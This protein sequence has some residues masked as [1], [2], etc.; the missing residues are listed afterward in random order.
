MANDQEV[1]I[2]SGEAN[3]TPPKPSP[4]QS[5]SGWDGKLRVTKQATL[6]NPEALSDPDYS[7]EDAPPVDQINADEDLLDDEDPDEIDVQHSRVSSMPALRLERF[8]RLR[9][10]CLR[11]N[12]IQHIELPPDFA[13]TLEELE[14][15]DNLVKHVGG[16]ED[17]TELRSLDLSYNKLKHIKNIST[18]TK[19]DHL[20]FVQNRLSKIENL[21]HLT[22]L[23]YLEL[24]ANRI[25]EIEGLETLT[26]LQHLWLGQNKITELKGLNGLAN[27]RTLSIQANR[28]T[29]LSGIE[30]LPHLTELYVSDNKIPSLEPLHQNTK[31][32]IL[33]FQTNPISSLAG[34]EELKELENVWASNCNIGDFREIERALKDKAKLEEV[35]FEG[36]PVQKQGPVLYRNKVRLALPQ[37]SKIDAAYVK[38]T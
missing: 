14:L 28:L 30:S 34:I 21:E 20:Y 9:R 18:L 22:D 6:A 32:E 19:L 27:L 13:P 17:F 23:V 26:K 7:D 31:L 16:L 35:Y 8:K 12:S 11:Q 38:V 29:S 25:R 3:E 15:Y 5:K 24:G 36:N 1:P 10:L 4:P 37:V 2:G 33:D